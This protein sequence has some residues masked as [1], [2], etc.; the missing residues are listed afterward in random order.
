MKDKFAIFTD[1]D[2]T[3][4]GA[5]GVNPKN[6]EIIKK[7][8]DMGHYVFVNSG[9]ARSFICPE[10][11]G[12]IE[13]DGIISGIGSRIDI[14][15]TTIYENLIDKDF[16]YECAKHFWDKPNSFSI[17]GPEQTIVKDPP[18]YFEKWHFP[19]LEALDDLKTFLKDYG[20]QKFEM[21]GKGITEED[22]N[23]FSDVLDVYDHGFYIECSPKGSSKA[24]AI[25]TVI[26]HLGIKKENSIAMGDS[27]NDIDMLKSVGTS[28]AVG[29][30]L[31][32]VKE[33]ADFLSTPCDDGGVGYAIEKLVFKI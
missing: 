25:K 8:R 15:K 14:G 23:F 29:N 11:I 13:F 9:R 17:S 20:V 32:E 10:L 3:L 21:F 2:G 28:V 19:K 18:P 16:I 24:L 7:A 5:K 26:D 22:K 1:I 31:D 30:A 27:I 33:I 4:S 6:A 12:N